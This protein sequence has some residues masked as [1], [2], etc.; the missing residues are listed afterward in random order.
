MAI[1]F[2]KEKQKQKYLVLILASLIFVTLGVVWWGVLREKKGVVNQLAP[3]FTQPEIQI[4]WQ[5]L[6]NTKLKELEIFEEISA[7]EEKIGRKNPFTPY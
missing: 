3:V 6:Q 5:I 2:I 7:P 1:T 4:D